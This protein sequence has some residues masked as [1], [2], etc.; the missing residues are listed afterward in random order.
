MWFWIGLVLIE[1]IPILFYRYVV[2]LGSF[3]MP[4][5]FTFIRFLSSNSI[6]YLADINMLNAGEILE[7]NLSPVYGIIRIAFLFL[8]YYWFKGNQEY[9]NRKWKEYISIALK[10]LD[11]QSEFS[12]GYFEGYHKA[13]KDNIRNNSSHYSDDFY[14][15]YD[16]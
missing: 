6:L 16:N 15:E 8:S 7:V 12:V 1:F 3:R 9:Q 10:N 11:H 5:I 14:D 13:Q 2:S 4:G